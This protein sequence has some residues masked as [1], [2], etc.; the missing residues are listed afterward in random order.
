MT[1]E[2][3]TAICINDDETAMIAAQLNERH[4]L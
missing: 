3:L 4:Q 2:K 1:V